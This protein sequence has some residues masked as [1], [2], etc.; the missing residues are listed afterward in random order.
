MQDIQGDV[1][2]EVGGDEQGKQRGGFNVRSE[3]REFLQFQ[4]Q[5][6]LGQNCA[7]N[8]QCGNIY[9]WDG[10]NIN[11][12]QQ[13]NQKGMSR[14]PRRAQQEE[15]KK[16][17]SDEEAL[18]EQVGVQSSEGTP[19]EEDSGEELINDNM[20]NDYKPIPELDRYESDGI[21]DEEVQGEMDYEQRR[22]AEEEIQ[23]RRRINMDDRRIPRAIQNLSD[24]EDEALDQFGERVYIEDP[25]EEEDTDVVEEERYLNIEE[26]RGKLNEWIKDDRTK[27]WIKRAFRKILNECKRGSD[28]EPIYIQLIKEMCKANKQSLE[29]LYPDLVSA[30]ATIALWVA[31]EPKII[32]PHLNEAARIEVNKR[33][34]HYHNI[35]QEIF[36]RIT[37]LPVVDIIRDLRYKHLDKFIRVIGVVTRRSAVYSQLKEITYVCVKCGMKKGPFYLENNDSIQLGVCIQC[38]S[39]GP[40]EKLYNQLVY[41][42]FQRLTLQE[43]PGQVPAGRVPRQKEVIVLGDQIDIARPGDEIEVTGVYTQRYDYALNVKHGFPLYSTIIE[44]NYIRRKDESE[45]LNID[46]K[47]KDEI[48]KLSQNPKIDKL[49]YNSVAP[50]IYGHQHVKMAIALAMFGGEAKDIQGKHRIRGDINVLVLGDPGTAKSQF[51]KNVQKT[52]YRSIYTTGKGASAVGLTASVQRDYSTNEWSISGGALVLAD[53]GICLIDEF[54]KMN[55]HDRTSIHEAMEQQSISISKAGI[56]TTLQARCSVIAAA[57]PVGG[58]YDSQQSFHDNV[59]L[60][61]PILS[62]FDILCVVKDEVIKEA[63]DRLA[64]FVINSHIRHHPMAAYELNNDP[65]SEW[66]QQIK[67]YFVKENKQTQEEVIPLELLKKYILYARTHIRPKLQN[68]DHEKIS[69][70]YYLLRKES[71]VCGGINIAIRHLESIIRMAEAHARMHLRNNVMDFDI[72]VAIKVMLESFL[73]SQKYSVARQLR[74]KFSDYLTFN[75]DSFDLLLNM[76]NKLYRQQKD[77]YQNIKNYNGDIR[78]PIQVLEKEA[79][80]NGVYFNSDFYDSTKFLEVYKRIQDYITLK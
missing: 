17:G 65:D 30:N 39:S 19:A 72:S 76:L 75:E 24:S 40:F 2:K 78:V 68:V 4:Q 25:F 49:I 51:L 71:E 62:R 69:K 7:K 52:F 59:D 41:R 45:S 50:S 70:F 8:K 29:V 3:V 44:S 63:D 26:C 38:Q 48:L 36:V 46:K 74:R 53:K 43:S 6:K 67:G 1:W 61:D 32:L 23:R 21:D 42:N 15:E 37:N 35:H 58:K 57:N 12:Y 55:E 56:V 79:K 34:N 54:D 66:S 33:F 80:T 77:Y 28:Q 22:R 47:I 60:T 9:I 64:S 31:E 73:Q 20:M 14:R 5:K 16:R 11:R 10:L 13:S 18:E 27:A